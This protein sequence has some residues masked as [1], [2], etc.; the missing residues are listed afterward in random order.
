MKRRIVRC[1]MMLLAALVTAVSGKGVCVAGELK[2]GDK[3]PSF[4]L[5]DQNG[6]PISLDALLAKGN[7]ALVFFRS[8]S[9]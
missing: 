9:W 8:A 3:A 6:N 7:V 4:T 5:K 1:V 2:V